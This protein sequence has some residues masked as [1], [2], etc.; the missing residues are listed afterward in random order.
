MS[1][2]EKSD[3]EAEFKA[4]IFCSTSAI[5]PAQL[6][7]WIEQ[8]SN[9]IDARIGVRYTT[10]II[11]YNSPKSFSLLKRICLFRVSERVKNKLEV[12]SNVSQKDSE[13]KYIENYVRTPNDDL[14]AIA[15]GTLLLSDATLINTQGAG[16]S[17]FTSD[18]CNPHLFDV[19]KQQW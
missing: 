2:C 11:S 4:T 3:I 6:I 14:A 1:Y 17:S 16:V 8:E 12:K 7:E 18:L 13:E 9:Y 10:P 5:T 15:K 19:R